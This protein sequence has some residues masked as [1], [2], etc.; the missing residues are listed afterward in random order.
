MFLELC[1]LSFVYLQHLF[2][3]TFLLLDLFLSTN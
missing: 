3:K 2:Y 1:S